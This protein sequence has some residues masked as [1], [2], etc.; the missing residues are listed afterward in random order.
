MDI[1]VSTVVLISAR[2]IV[3]SSTFCSRKKNSVVIEIILCGHCCKYCIDYK[4]RTV[5]SSAFCNRKEGSVV[6]KK[7]L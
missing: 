1:V 5:F 3:F 7:I 6:G 2:S 4:E